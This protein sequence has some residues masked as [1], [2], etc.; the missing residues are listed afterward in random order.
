M[1]NIAPTETLQSRDIMNHAR[2]PPVRL[3][4]LGER[5]P[6][7]QKVIGSRPVLDIYLQIIKGDEYHESKTKTKD[8]VP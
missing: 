6:Y 1:E 5:L 3:A 7:K 2:V 4:H 8:H